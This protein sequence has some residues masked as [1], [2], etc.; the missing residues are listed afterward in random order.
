MTVIA[1]GLSAQ[2]LLSGQDGKTG[3]GI[4]SS[5]RN[6]IPIQ[7]IKIAV[8]V[9][10]IVTQF[11]F[12]ANVV[13]PGVYQSFLDGV[14][15]LN[16][17]LTWVTGCIFDTDF[18]DRLLVSTIGPLIALVCLSFTYCLGRRIHTHSE[19][20]LKIVKE[21]HLSATLLLTFL[22]YSSVS[23]VLFQTFA[24]ED[25]ED[26]NNYLR[27]DYRIECDSEKHEHMQ[28]YSWVMI[29]LYTIGIP[30]WYMYLMFNKNMET[31]SA[32]SLWESYKSDRFYYEIVECARRVL[33]TGV[34][35]FIYLNTAAQIA[36]TLMIAFAFFGISES[37][38]PYISKWDKWVN[39]MGHIIVYAS[40]YIALLLRVNVSDEREDSQKFF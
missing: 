20:A 4:W 33:L 19:S 34:V 39:R 30:V 40:M 11:S 3:T 17:D 16:F 38:S 18:H 12:V 14:D 2:Y 27:S 5:I 26:G 9:W 13:Y 10:Q 36:I 32:R 28:I 21:T 7:S 1:L 6:H 15:L 25:L 23:S 35:V 29:C 24:C 8:V 22:V 37:L 31:S